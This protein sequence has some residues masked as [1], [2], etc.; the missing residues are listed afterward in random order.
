MN[1]PSVT[2]KCSSR[3]PAGALTFVAHHSNVLCS[4]STN[5]LPKKFPGKRKICCPL[6]EAQRDSL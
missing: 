1:L 3:L 6:G 2:L 5:A 4:V